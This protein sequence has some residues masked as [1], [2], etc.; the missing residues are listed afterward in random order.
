M[1]DTDGR[2]KSVGRPVD[3]PRPRQ[4]EERANDT[5]SSIERKPNSRSQLTDSQSTTN[6]QPIHNQPTVDRPSINDGRDG[7]SYEYEHEREH[8]RDRVYWN[9]CTACR[10]RTI[11]PIASRRATE[12]ASANA[13][14]AAIARKI[15]SAIANVADNKNHPTR[16]NLRTRLDH[17]DQ[18]DR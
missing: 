1:D 6:Q 12:T 13:S 8:E 16:T 17:L 7:Q 2:L 9:G 11:R 14:G 5:Q 3:R 18:L 4:H 15:A 10:V